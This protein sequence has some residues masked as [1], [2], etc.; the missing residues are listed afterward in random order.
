MIESLPP[1]SSLHAFVLVA[2]TGSLA[3]AADRLNVTQPAI[4]KRIRMLEAHLGVALVRRGANALRLTPEGESYAT[5]LAGAFSEIR[6]ATAALAAPASG[7]LRV[8]AYTTWA[9]RWLIPRLS[10]FRERHSGLEV[11]VT[12]SV[13]PVDFS[14]EQVDAAIRTSDRPPAPGAERLHKVT[15][16]PFAA[17]GPARAAKRGGLAGVTLLG[18]VV[19]PQDW[20]I[21][22]KVTGTALPATPLLFESTSLAVQAAIEGLGAVIAPPLLVAEDVRRR[23]LVGLAQGDVA[24]GDHYWLVLP[25]GPARREALAFRDWLVRELGG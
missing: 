5:A 10:R 4:S 8:R 1:L 23:R 9:L 12:T 14:R 25:P 7:P 6:T 11:E 21:W 22:A 3:A 13:T 19:R 2:E 20:G 17:P 18:S 24:T 15:I 16:A